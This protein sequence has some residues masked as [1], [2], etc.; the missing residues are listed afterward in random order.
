MP[1]SATPTSVPPDGEPSTGDVLAYISDMLGQLADLAR[2]MDK[3]RL[4]LAIRLLALEAATEARPGA[5]G[6]AAG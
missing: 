4:E 6:G 5:S 1:L 3:R 2:G